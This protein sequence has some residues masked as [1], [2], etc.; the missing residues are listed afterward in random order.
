MMKIG[1]TIDESRI[2]GQLA[3][4][5][6]DLSYYVEIGMW[7]V[8]IPPHGLDVIKNG[9]LDRGR[10][11]EVKEILDD[12][13]FHY[14]VHAPDPI[15]LMD[16][17]NY[18][19]HLAVLKSSMEFAL[20]IG[21]NT[22][23]YHPGRFIPEERFPFYERVKISEIEK[24]ILLEVEAV[25]IAALAEEFSEITICME[26]ARPYKYHSPYS[27]AERLDAL[28]KQVERI[29]REN[30]KI[31]LDLG[32]LYLASRLYGFDPADTVLQVKE[33]IGHTHIHDNCGNLDFYHEK[34]L[35]RLIP[36]GKGD[37]HMPVGWGEI[38]IKEI[39][40]NISDSFQ[41]VLMME[42]RGRYFDYIEESKMRLEEIVSEIFN[43]SYYDAGKYQAFN[44]I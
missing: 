42:V 23:V 11:R 32:H 4:L 33:M 22:V 13:D 17:E 8:E 31:N 18:Q 1:N 7:A 26:N 24:E 35:T 10:T 19:L 37:T 41:G 25:T 30:V 34:Q 40:S 28:K 36:F 43:N 21:A 27:Y 3:R 9:K 5:I 15:N 14:S 38:P 20:E 12:F 16:R 44:L 2:D 6:D 29:G 39:L